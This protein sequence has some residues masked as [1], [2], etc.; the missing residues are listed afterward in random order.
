MEE[1][2]YYKILG[3]PKN[4]SEAEIKTAYRKKGKTFLSIWIKKMKQ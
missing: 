1:T 3:V 2:N 4:A